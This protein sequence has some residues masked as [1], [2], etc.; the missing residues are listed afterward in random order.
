MIAT[1]SVTLV[2]GTDLI[3]IAEVEASVARFGDRYLRRVFTD[4]ELD[5]TRG[6]QQGARLAARFAAKE[7][8]LKALR[9]G[10]A[11]IPWRSIEVRRA[12]DGAPE[13]QLHGAAAELAESQGI[14]DLAL[15][16]THETA[17][18]AAVVVGTKRPPTT[19]PST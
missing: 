13:I 12:A 6:H 10:D 1:P 18:A 11:A 3:A 7:A 19:S 14:A 17:F 15:S 8:M 5:E 4:L 16:I 2:I 9:V